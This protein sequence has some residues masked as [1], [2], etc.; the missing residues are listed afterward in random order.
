MAKELES[1][2]KEEAKAKKDNE[3]NSLKAQA[4]KKPKKSI[5]KYF[6]DA[7][8]EFKKVVWPSRK[9]VFNNTVVV[10]VSLVVSGIAIW[11]VDTIFNIALMLALGK[12][13]F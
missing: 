3:K 4:A 11:G 10:I 9:Q 7:R 13:I 12:P 8:S 6:K 5:V 1:L 2:S